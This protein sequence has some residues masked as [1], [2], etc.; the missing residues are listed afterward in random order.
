MVDKQELEEHEYTTSGD[1][2]RTLKI[3]LFLTDDE[4]GEFKWMKDFV[5]ECTCDGVTVANALARYIHRESIRSEF[6]ERMEEPTEETCDVTFNVFDRYGRVQPKYKDHPVQ[7]GTGVWGDELDHGPLFLIETLHVSAPELRRKGLGRKVVSLLLEKAR[8]F[9]QDKKP[10]GEDAPLKYGSN[11]AFERAWTLHALV[12]PGYL[13]ADLEPQLE[14]KSTEERLMAQDRSESGATAFW[15]SCGFRRIGASRWLAFSFDLQH[16]SRALAASSDFDP[17]RSRED[18]EL[19]IHG[20]DP[21][22][23]AK[24][25]KM[26]RLRDALPLHHASLTLPDEELRAFFVTHADDKISWDRVTSSEATP[27]HL[28]ACELKPLSTRWLLENVYHADSW[29]AAR[30]IDGYTPFEALQEKLDESR[31]REGYGH[32]GISNVPDGFEGYPDAAVSCLSLL[33]GQDALRPS[34]ECLRYGCSCGECVGGF[35][36]ARMRSSL[37]LQGELMHDLLKDGID[38]GSSWIEYNDDII[39]HLDPNVRRNLKTNKSLRRGF[40]NMFRVAVECLKANRVPSAE[41]L[42]WQCNNQSERPPYSK[43]YLRRAG[44]QM[45]CR[46]VLRYMFDTAEEEDE[47]ERKGEDDGLTLKRESSNLPHCRNDYEFEFVAWLC[48]YSEG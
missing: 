9:L 5:A 39:V 8:Q 48:G 13:T 47:K 23:Q 27:L 2:A 19:D 15:R 38:D 42:E 7:R 35:L 14:G 1:P 4:M 37:I 3:R 17:P 24:K 16:Q 33:L 26:E 28:T 11:D 44:V 6:R 30:D 29:K 21:S 41:N 31:T 10:D 34:E 45:G 12:S 46:A 18:E 43:N 25:P 36:S 40:A 22:T 20:P 32:L